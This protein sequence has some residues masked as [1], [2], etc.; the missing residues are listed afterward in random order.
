MGL[1]QRRKGAVGERELGALVRDLTGWDVQ[2]RCRQ[3]DGDSDMLGVPGWAI[4]SKRHKVA[5]PGD[6]ASWWRQTVEQA[7]GGI[8]VL[9]YRADRREW[10]A[11]WPLSVL[12]VEQTSGMWEGIEWTAETSVDAWA[13]VARQVYR[14][15]EVSGTE[16]IAA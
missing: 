12:M 13:A 2:R 1:M 7:N 9:F 8:P 10:R 14:P 5:K 3:H 15:V 11:V 6:I 16:L 4:E